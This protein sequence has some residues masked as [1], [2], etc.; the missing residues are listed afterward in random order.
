[1]PPQEEELDEEISKLKAIHQLLEKHK[2]KM[3][4]LSY[5]QRKFDEATKEMCNI[6][7]HENLN[8]FRDQDYDGRDHDNLRHE[9]FR[10]ALSC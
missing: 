6:E 3:L 1:L 2:E 4:R 5:L 9:V 8:N 10:R 7:A